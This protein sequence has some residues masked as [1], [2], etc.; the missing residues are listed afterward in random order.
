MLL[1]LQPRVSE[2]LS[3]LSPSQP[4]TSPLVRHRAESTRFSSESDFAVCHTHSPPSQP[5]P[6]A[7]IGN[8][9]HSVKNNKT[10]GRTSGQTKTRRT[11]AAP[12]RTT[13]SVCAVP[14][15]TAGPYADPT[16]PAQRLP[17]D[18]I[19]NAEPRVA[20]LTP[21]APRQTEAPHRRVTA[22]LGKFSA[23]SDALCVGAAVFKAAPSAAAVQP[24]VLRTPNGTAERH[25]RAPQ[26][27]ECGVTTGSDGRTRGVP[28]ADGADRADGPPAPP[29]PS[30]PFVR[31]RPARRHG[32]HPP[33]PRGAPGAQPTGRGAAAGTGGARRGRRAAN[34]RSAPSRARSVP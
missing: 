3:A 27:G 23:S 10:A 7:S 32:R 1:K 18:P 21:N 29:L 16:R 20:A 26:D 5:L 24:P 6:A 34:G 11:K 13:A 31:G 12:L 19:P 22:P 30:R 2:R 9:S 28:T 14:N 17:A 15:L 33:P 25:R 8:R 4:P